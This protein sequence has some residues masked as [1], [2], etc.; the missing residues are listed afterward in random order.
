MVEGVWRG[1]F[2]EGP[3]GRLNLPR[4]SDLIRGY[5]NT[6]KLKHSVKGSIASWS[7]ASHNWSQGQW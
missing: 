5:T 3:G 6:P 4:I 7:P 1:M 2:V